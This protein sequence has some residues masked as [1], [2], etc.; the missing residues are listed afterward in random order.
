MTEYQELDLIGIS[1]YCPT[2]IKWGFDILRSLVMGPKARAYLR[3]AHA[4]EISQ[5][6]FG[7]VTPDR[8][9]RIE[10]IIV[11]T[12]SPNLHP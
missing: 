1:S 10:S 4:G 7:P 3:G 6:A 5:K 9:K 11:R 2:D 8:A 12:F